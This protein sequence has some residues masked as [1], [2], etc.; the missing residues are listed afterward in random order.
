M[1]IIVYMKK[2]P[3]NK[4]ETLQAFSLITQLGL[5]MIV[6]IGMTSALGIWLD[7]RF[8]TGFFTVI[9]FFIGAVAGGQG[10]YR[11]IKQLDGDEENKDD[12][13]TKK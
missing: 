10:A 3:D 11:M 9:F 2:R 6:S 13:L 7:R 1:G 8:G 12:Y 5:V 4:K